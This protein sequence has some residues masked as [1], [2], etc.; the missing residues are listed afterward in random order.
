M[1]GLWRVEDGSVSLHVVVCKV[2][3]FT[4]HTKDLN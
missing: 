2:R 3:V 4:S 1:A